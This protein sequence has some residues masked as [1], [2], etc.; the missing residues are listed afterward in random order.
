M[1]T[2]GTIFFTCERWP[3]DVMTDP[4]TELNPPFEILEPSEWAGAIVFNSPH[5][6]N[7]YPRSFLT[8]ARLDLASLRRSEDSFV[9]ELFLGVV[10]RGHP[11]M[12]AHFPRCYVD[13]NR[14]PYELDPRMF[15]G[16]LPSFAN[17]RSMRVAGG[18]GTVARVVGDAQE[19]YDQRIPVDDAL[20]RIEELYKPY[21]RALRRLVTKVHRQCG[22]AVLV[23]CH[24]MPS[25]AGAKDERPRADVVLGD[26]YGTS[27]VA[28]VSETI[29]S[30]L[31]EL[32]YSVSRNKPYAGGFITEHYGN[33]SAGLHAIQLEINRGLYMDERRY[34]RAARFSRLAA[35]LE[36]LADRLGRM[37]IDEIRPYRAAAE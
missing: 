25:T 18:L 5:S 19:I 20:G 30:T 28:I 17:T 29:E 33:P 7:I 23:D 14:E 37:P 34:E 11:L 6:G 21:H 9:D 27:C 24:S 31:T 3:H 4:K 1:R 13:V 2:E 12:R 26:R 32:G 35:D 16:R 22:A 15:E 36:T 8:A 10:Q